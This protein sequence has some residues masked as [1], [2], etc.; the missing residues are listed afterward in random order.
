VEKLEDKVRQRLVRV[1]GDSHEFTADDGLAMH[2]VDSLEYDIT[3]QGRTVRFS[4]FD[5]Q[6]RPPKK[7]VLREDETYVGPCF[8]ESGLRFHLIFNRDLKRLYWILDD[9]TF[10]SEIFVPLTKHVVLGARTGFAFFDDTL[11]HRKV[12]IGVDGLNVLQNNWYDGPFDQ[13][14]DNLVQ[15]GKIRVKDYLLAHYKLPADVI[16]DFGRYVGE[17]GSRVP[18]APYRVYFSTSDLRSVD[19]C[20]ELNMPRPQLYGE[21]TKQIYNAPKEYLP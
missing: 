17:R 20:V 12:L 7:G 1:R 2:K 21:I 10:V 5:L 9:E 6:P 13:M 8:D 19:S 4:L 18:V 11:Q 16:D 3:Y 15:A 14:P